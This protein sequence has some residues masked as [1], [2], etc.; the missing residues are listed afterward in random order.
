MS[1]VSE[2]EVPAEMI[3]T[4]SNA[5]YHAS[6]PVSRSRLWEMRKTPAYFRYCEAHPKERTAAMILG[7]A[8]HT[9]VLEPEKFER[10]YYVVY[11]EVKRRSN[12]GKAAWAAMVEETG[13]RTMLSEEDY[14]TVR[15]MAD[16]VRYNGMASYLTHGEVEQSYYVTDELTGIPY[17]V[18][19]DCF[20]MI[21]GRGLIV[22]LK[23]TT[24]A[25]T[26]AFRREAIRLGYDFQAAMYKT[27]VEKERGIECDFVFIAVEK[28]PP[29]LI[30]IMQCD[31]L[32]ITRGTDLFREYIGIYKD[33]LA[34]GNWY[35]YNGAL[36][37]INNLAL[38]AYLA[39]EIE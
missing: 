34:T 36:N 28:E 37:V 20:K 31:P 1:C 2:S 17:K 25:S 22:D 39:K 5:D 38:P 15:G 7:S 18:R 9:A 26:D 33:C 4:E 3:K 12:A 16:A 8:F 35:G 27:A 19:P 24:D 29:Y 11:G 32:W 14:R 10:E 6:T 13:D 30:N 21:N 23:S